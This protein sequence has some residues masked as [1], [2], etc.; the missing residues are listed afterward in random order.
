[1][2]VR[3]RELIDCVAGIFA[4]VNVLGHQLGKRVGIELSDTHDHSPVTLYNQLDRERAIRTWTSRGILAIMIL[5][6]VAG[7][8][9]I[10]WT[11]WG[12]A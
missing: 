4:L 12:G 6:S 10:A 7:V 8:A 2:T 3:S 9:T 1:M 5:G 11:I